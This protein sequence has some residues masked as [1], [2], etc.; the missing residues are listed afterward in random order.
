MRCRYRDRQKEKRIMARDEN[1]KIFS[2]YRRKGK[3]RSRTAGGSEAFRGGAGADPGDDG[4]HGPD[5]GA[6]T[7]S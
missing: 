6:C 7:E 5:A 3:E 1:V 2:G 4:S